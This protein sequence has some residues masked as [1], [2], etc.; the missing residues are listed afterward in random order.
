MFEDDFRQ[1][2]QVDEL[3]QLLLGRRHALG[4]SSASNGGQFDTAIR[5]RRP[6]IVRRQL[7]LDV[8]HFRDVDRRR[9]IKGSSGQ[10]VRFLLQFRQFGFIRILIED[11][12]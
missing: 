10:S 11:R 3:L 6:G 7:Q 4:Q 9:E 12:L 8:E 1:R 2:M 5:R